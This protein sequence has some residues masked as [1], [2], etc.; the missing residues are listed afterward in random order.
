MEHLDNKERQE[1]L[2]QVGPLVQQGLLD[3]RERL[4][5]GD[6]MVNR[7]KLET[8]V[9]LVPQVPQ[10]RLV[11]QEKLDYLDQE[12]QLAPQVQLDRQEKLVIEEIQEAKDPKDLKEL[13]ELVVQVE[14]LALQ[15]KEAH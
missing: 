6:K 9:Q 8:V 14:V 13:K 10:E 11:V 7:V 15:E 4:G 5:V 1:Q 12:G 2:V 3:P